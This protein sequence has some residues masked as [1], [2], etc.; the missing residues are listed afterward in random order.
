MATN[1]LYR[2]ERTQR[3]PPPMLSLEITASGEVSATSNSTD[4]FRL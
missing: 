2:T 4:K 1:P 3:T